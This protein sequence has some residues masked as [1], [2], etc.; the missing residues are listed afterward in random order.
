MA[1]YA[2]KHSFRETA[3]KFN[4][5]G[6]DGLP[7]KGLAEQ[8][9]KGYE[10]KKPETRIRIGLPAEI[11]APVHRRTI[12]DHMAHDD[13]IDMP[14]PLLAHALLIREEFA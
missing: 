14:G 11:P 9:I 4:I 7:S 13:L 2:K 3:E 5:L 6:P 12:N 10:P 1:L 8:I